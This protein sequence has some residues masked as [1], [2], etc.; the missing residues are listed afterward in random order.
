RSL[1][2]CLLIQLR[3]KKS[4]P[5]I[6]LAISIL[7][8][9]FDAFTKKH[10]DKLLSKYDITE[11]QLRDAS[12]E[13]SSL[14]PKPGGSYS[15]NIHNAEHV[16]P[17]FTISIK[18]G[19]LDLTLNG[20]N[21]PEMHVSPRYKEMLKGYKAAKKKTRKQK[22]AIMFI[23]QKLDSAKWFIDAIIQRQQTLLLTMDAIMTYQ[24]DYFMSGDE[25]D[26]RPMILK[27]IA[28]KIDMDVSTV[29][30]VAN[31]KYVDTPYGT[32]L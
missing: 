8:N 25:R 31:S 5:D 11:D 24:H 23:K 20:R 28:E 9:S 12:E 16:I 2:E 3:R 17:D 27:D 13:I 32:F 26:L 7:E 19:E 6:S 18:D 22:D 10:Y 29:S 30:R 4:T 14:N 21:A 15:N 1:R